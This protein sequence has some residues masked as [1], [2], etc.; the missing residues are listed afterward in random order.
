MDDHDGSINNGLTELILFLIDIDNCRKS[1][2]IIT[3]NNLS[4]GRRCTK[5]APQKTWLYL[6]RTDYLDYL[7]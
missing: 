6:C 4:D 2:Q 1:S 5:Q 7:K 3:E